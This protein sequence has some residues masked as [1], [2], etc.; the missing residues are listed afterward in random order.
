M[1][2]IIYISNGEKQIA[3]R[4]ETINQLKYFTLWLEKYQNS[5][6][7]EN[8]I[9]I[10]QD[11]DVF[12]H[13]I[14]YL[15]NG[16]QYNLPLTIIETLNN[17]VEYDEELVKQIEIIELNVGGKIF[18]TTKNTLCKS[19]YFDALFNRFDGKLGFID[20]DP[21]NFKYILSYLRNNSYQIPDNVQYD[22]IFYGLDTN[23][24]IVKPPPDLY[25]EPDYDSSYDFDN[26]WQ[27]NDCAVYLSG[28]AQ[29]TFFKKVYRRYTDFLQDYL[30]I[31]PNNGSML[32]TTVEWDIS[33]IHTDLLANA[34][35]FIEYNLPIN[36]DINLGY[37]LIKNIKFSANKHPQ[38]DSTEN[39]I[40]LNSIDGE[41]LYIQMNTLYKKKIK[42]LQKQLCSAFPDKTFIIIPI[43]MFLDNS[44]GIAFPL[45]AYDKII[46]IELELYKIT[47]FIQQS[48]ELINHNKLNALLTIEKIRLCDEEK[49]RFINTSHEYL[50]TKYSKYEYNFNN[51]KFNEVIN[52]K[53]KC[54]KTIF[55][56]I[57]NL[58]VE[59][60]DLIYNHVNIY[61]KLLGDGKVIK[62]INPII[63]SIYQTKFKHN[64][65]YIISFSIEESQSGN[66][67]GA[68]TLSN[69]TKLEF[70][71]ELSQKQGKIK[72]WFEYYDVLRIIN[73]TIGF[74][75]V[76]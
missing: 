54:I 21:D 32:G 53:N 48:E 56:G 30:T 58:D 43:S 4:Y 26:Q 71:L 2:K 57:Q 22:L 67:S 11:T 16:D 49:N 24:N 23:L 73:K 70:N 38:I 3:T 63:N 65:I 7:Q 34:Y 47:D 66:P 20:R 19:P 52:I 6:T 41:L 33:K 60:F 9:F 14:E 37:K 75:N 42:I 59:P 68:L 10:D 31:P 25:L 12:N 39:S 35:L 18:K 64:N 62:H 55:I 27:N 29:V 46:T 45:I 74:Q 28:S 51:F 8:P 5:G 40:I 17:L 69:K 15:R 36:S 76:P 13:I 72:I 61:G 50:I 44:H 1:N